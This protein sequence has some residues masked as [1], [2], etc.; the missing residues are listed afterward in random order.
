[1]MALMV[2]FEPPSAWLSGGSALSDFEENFRKVVKAFGLQ[3]VI[4][5]L[6][7]GSEDLGSNQ[8]L[9][10]ICVTSFESKPPMTVDQATTLIHR[11][12]VEKAHILSFQFDTFEDLDGVFLGDPDE[13]EEK[14]EVSERAQV[15]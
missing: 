5:K 2:V 1:M 7:G 13:Q 6:E 9:Y 3:Y 10:E 14:D 8:D 15:N 12:D 4:G 11:V